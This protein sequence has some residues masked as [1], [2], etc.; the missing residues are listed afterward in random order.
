MYRNL[1]ERNRKDLKN[2]CKMGFVICLVV[3]MLTTVVGITVYEVVFDPGNTG[4]NPEMSISIAGG[5]LLLSV[6]LKFLINHKYYSDL[7]NNK[8]VLLTK[9]LAGKSKSLDSFGFKEANLSKGT[10][11]RFEFIVDDIKFRIDESLYQS[12]ADGDKLVFSYAPKSKYLL[13]IEK[14]KENKLI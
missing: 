11:N 6:L 10:I 8:K 2:Q 9:K 5:V 1:T 12:C 13:D 14:S 4:L 3:F 7:R